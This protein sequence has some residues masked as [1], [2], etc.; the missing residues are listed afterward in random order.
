MDLSYRQTRTSQIYFGEGRKRFSLP[1]KE[2]PASLY[3]VI[4]FSSSASLCI[5]I[6][7][8]LS[9]MSCHLPAPCTGFSSGSA[10]HKHS[11]T[12]FLSGRPQH[13]WESTGRCDFSIWKHA[14]CVVLWRLQLMIWFPDFFAFNRKGC[15]TDTW[16]ARLE[17]G[18]LALPP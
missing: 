12:L 9:M 17:A 2:I 11:P 18:A 14:L 3:L 15:P 10:W 8:Y 13:C 5:Y 7:I 4:Y 16:Q 6:Y 1:E